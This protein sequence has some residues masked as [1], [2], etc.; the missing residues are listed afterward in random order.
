LGAGAGDGQYAARK[1]EQDK[2]RKDHNFF[3]SGHRNFMTLVTPI[4]SLLPISSLL[5]TVTKEPMEISSKVS[6]ISLGTASLL[7]L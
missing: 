7:N 2:H 1:K 3:I 6:G 5:T 4:V